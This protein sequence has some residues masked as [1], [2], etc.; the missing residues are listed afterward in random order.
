M[1]KQTVTYDH[2]EQAFGRVIERNRTGKT[3]I[4]CPREAM[5]AP[6]FFVL[7]T[8]TDIE[9]PAFGLVPD[10]LPFESMWIVTAYKGIAVCAFV[11]WMPALQMIRPDYLWYPQPMPGLRIRT[12]EYEIDGAAAWVIDATIKTL[13]HH[14]LEEVESPVRNRINLRRAQQNTA[15]PVPPLPEF[16]RI[17]RTPV[18]HSQSSGTGE[19]VS[20][21]G[22]ERRGHW[23]TYK[24]SGKQVWINSTSVNGG[25][26]VARN[27]R[28]SV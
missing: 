8:E 13:L 18:D 28:L 25:S 2:L 11:E 15:S 21:Q 23:R 26:P 6:A 19:R 20:P 12:T 10:R 14:N 17:R 22:H 24:A 7:P 9:V 1:T 27:Y 4:P 16:I 5:F 3:L